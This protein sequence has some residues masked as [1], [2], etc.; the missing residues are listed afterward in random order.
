[1]YGSSDQAEIAAGSQVLPRRPKQRVTTGRFS[2]RSYSS[3][4]IT[5][6]RFFVE[7]DL[8]KTSWKKEL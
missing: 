4:E 1:L 7:T 6:G 3:D 5:P 2:S 8:G